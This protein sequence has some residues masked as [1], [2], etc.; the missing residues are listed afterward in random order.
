M[1]Y[2][3]DPLVLHQCVQKSVEEAKIKGLYQ[4]P[5]T[6]I[7]SSE[8]HINQILD[9]VI[10]EIAKKY[11]KYIYNGERKWIM[12]N[13]GGG[14]GQLCILHSS[15]N[16]YISIYGTPLST[17]SHSGRYRVTMY[18]YILAGEVH[19]FKEG[20]ITCYKEEVGNML[21]LNSR[22]VKGSSIPH[23]A[24]LLEYGRGFIASALPFGVADSLFSTLDYRTIFKTL[25]EYTVHTFRSFKR[26][27]FL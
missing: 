4:I 12:N 6:E 21:T 19:Y 25:K 11:P 13:A 22:E 16:E 26:G 18:D 7:A 10:T 15:L 8:Q 14:M 5:K 3:F 2:I 27:K 17:Q 1:S 23:G 9:L 24:W 20:S